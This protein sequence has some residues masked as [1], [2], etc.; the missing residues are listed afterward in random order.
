[1]VSNLDF[2]SSDLDS[3]PSG[4]S[5]T[6][7]IIFTYQK[8]KKKTKISNLQHV[9]TENGNSNPKFNLNYEKRWKN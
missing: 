7:L 2:E 1:M 5:F 9:K 8:K 6:L 4:T 3:T